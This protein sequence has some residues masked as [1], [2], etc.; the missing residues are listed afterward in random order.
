MGLNP[1]LANGRYQEIQ[2]IAGQESFT[3]FEFAA[4]PALKM[5]ARLPDSQH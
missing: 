4:K 2:R 5:S 3:N 1:A